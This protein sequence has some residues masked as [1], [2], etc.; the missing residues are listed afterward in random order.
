MKCHSLSGVKLIALHKQLD[1]NHIYIYIHF[2]KDYPVLNICNHLANNDYIIIDTQPH[3]HK[4][5]H[6]HAPVSP[7][8]PTQIRITISELPALSQNSLP[9][10][11]GFQTLHSNNLIMQ[12]HWN[13]ED[14][15]GSCMSIFAVVFP[16][17]KV[18][19]SVPMQP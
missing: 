15:T 13:L 14:K 16:L 10:T 9:L 4:E 17:G 8:T 2:N 11:F 1:K 3:L 12:V 19:F 18:V 5:T 7:P 6:L